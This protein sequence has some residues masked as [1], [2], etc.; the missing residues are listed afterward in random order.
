MSVKL[1]IQYFGDLHGELFSRE[2]PDVK[3]RKGHMSDTLFDNGHP[4]S[5]NSPERY[6]LKGGLCRVASVI[7]KFR[8]S[9]TYDSKFVVS[10]GDMLGGNAVQLFSQ[11]QVIV[12]ALNKLRDLFGSDYHKYHALGN[13]DFLY[14]ER[15]TEFTFR[16]GDLSLLAPSSTQP[17]WLPAPQVQELAYLEA[18]SLAMNIYKTGVVG[19]DDPVP[20]FDP[21]SVEE[22]V[23]NGVALRIGVIGLTTDRRVGLYASMMQNYKIDGLVNNNIGTSIKERFVKT[24]R[25]LRLEE[26]CNVVMVISEFGIGGNYELAELEELEDTP[27]DVIASSDMHEVPKTKTCHHCRKDGMLTPRNNTLIVEPGCCGEFVWELSFEFSYNEQTQRYNLKRKRAIIRDTGPYVPE[28]PVMKQYI[29]DLINN[30]HF[31]TSHAMLEYPRINAN[32]QNSGATWPSGLGVDPLKM[33]IER[34]KIFP[35]KGMVDRPGEAAGI[36]YDPSGET[37]E[38][39]PAVKNKEWMRQGG[40]HRYNYATHPH[41]PALLEGTMSNF[42]TLCAC[43]TAGTRIACMRGFRY[44]A[45]VASPGNLTQDSEI[46]SGYGSGNLTVGDIFNSVAPTWYLGRGY[47]N[48]LQLRNLIRNSTFTTI[49]GNPET[50]R[51]GWGFAWAGLRITYDHENLMALQQGRLSGPADITIKKLEILKGPTPGDYT[52]PSVWYALDSAGNPANLTA[53]T[54]DQWE[55]ITNAPNGAWISIASH[56]TPD[57]RHK[58]NN[59]PQREEVIPGANVNPGESGGKFN[60]GLVRTVLNA[61]LSVPC[62]AGNISM[63]NPAYLPSSDDHY[64]NT[65]CLNPAKGDSELMPMSEACIQLMEKLQALSTISVPFTSGSPPSSASPTETWDAR[66]A[67]VQSIVNPYQKL[68]RV[69]SGNPTTIVSTTRIKVD[70]APVGVKLYGNHHETLEQLGFN[71]MQPFILK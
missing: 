27:V 66:D 50:W 53:P 40:F 12:K 21:Y 24:V 41:F 65:I 7:S 9:R 58:V 46:P 62:G 17:E 63:P 15:V 1:G 47:C 30:T 38:K 29:I 37:Q 39:D 56:T 31:P 6:I 36:L 61:S 19:Y 16:Q 48:M 45:M 22:R 52:D 60:G 33:T 2:F 64:K 43:I 55:D 35:L 18:Q 25:K 23:I 68:P 14:G 67:F 4:G 44:G 11:G 32:I 34:S 42:V 70:G 10:S 51:G 54:E 8:Q 49:N 71:V 28:H 26:H 57:A 69:A 3:T 13:W 5:G 59:F 20:L